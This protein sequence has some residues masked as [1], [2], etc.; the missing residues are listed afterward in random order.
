MFG[1]LPLYDKTKK[2]RSPTSNFAI[3]P[4]RAAIRMTPPTNTMIG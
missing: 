1:V 4:E 3:P 2:S